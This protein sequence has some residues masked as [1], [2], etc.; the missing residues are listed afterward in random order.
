MP[1]D[2]TAPAPSPA[3][4]PPVSL[5]AQIADLVNDPAVARDHWGIMVT[6]LDG[7]LIYG[8]NQGQLFRP[9]SNAKL[10]TTTAA[11]ALLG[12][13]STLETKVSGALDSATGRVRG[14]LVLKGAGDANFDSGDL[15]YVA[16]A[17]RPNN[18][19]HVPH[20][21]HDIDDLVNQ[22]IA[23]GVK[24]VDGDIVGDDTLFPWEPFG[25]NWSIDDAVWGYGAPV[26]ALTIADNEL[27]LTMA[28]G[29]KAGA[30]AR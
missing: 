15:P 11:M 26:S 13:E 7:G 1:A 10:Y 27:R 28:A 21:L 25:A 22:L 24:Q 5:A 20:A 19:P 6:N 2:Q 4:L 17:S 12:P 14:D 8:L 18:V 16:P 29:A 23:K 3:N 9:A 30:Q